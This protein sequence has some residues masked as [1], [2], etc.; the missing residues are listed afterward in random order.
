MCNQVYEDES[1]GV[2]TRNDDKPSSTAQKKCIHN[3]SGS[4]SDS[5]PPTG[6]ADP[7]LDI[8]SDVLDPHVDLATVTRYFRR[9]DLDMS[10]TINT[11]EEVSQLCL[12]LAVVSNMEVDMETLDAC[13]KDKAVNIAANPMDVHSFHEWWNTTLMRL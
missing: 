6:E 12:N 8:R 1:Y 2:E 10:G 11:A 5:E 4:Q 13:V 3:D 7:I 9:Y